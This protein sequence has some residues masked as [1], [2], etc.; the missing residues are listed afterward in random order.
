MTLEITGWTV[1]GAFVL[2]FVVVLASVAWVLLKFVNQKPDIPKQVDK[3][4]G[5]KSQGSSLENT[6]ATNGSS[7]KADTSQ[8]QLGKG[9]FDEKFAT[10]EE[11]FEKSKESRTPRGVGEIKDSV[12]KATEEIRKSG[13]HVSQLKQQFDGFQEQQNKLSGQLVEVIEKQAQLPSL[14]DQEFSRLPASIL[15]KFNDALDGSVHIEELNNTVSSTLERYLRSLRDFLEAQGYKECKTCGEAA[16]PKNA[17]Y[18][19]QCSGT[20]F[21]ASN[22]PV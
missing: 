14:L 12:S 20:E 11:T 18:C 15:P 1:V 10:L 16:V 13:D 8:D 6:D 19:P 3:N 7:K 17:V 2:V 21:T 22:T 5:E 4:E 9:Y